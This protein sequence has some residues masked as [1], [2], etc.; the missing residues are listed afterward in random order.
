[1]DSARVKRYR[2]LWYDGFPILFQIGLVVLTD[3]KDLSDIYED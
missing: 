1:M 3:L 2:D